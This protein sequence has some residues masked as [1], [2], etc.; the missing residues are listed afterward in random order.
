MTQTTIAALPTFSA[1]AGAPDT[2]LS[3]PLAP[4]DLILVFGCENAAT[5][6]R[7]AMKAAGL[8]HAG[9]APKILLSGGV[10]N[11]TG[12]LEARHMNTTLRM[13]GVP[14]RDIHLETWSSNTLENAH[15]S[16]GLSPVIGLPAR[17]AVILINQAHASLRAAMTMA[18][19][20]PDALC[21]YAPV[22]SAGVDPRNWRKDAHMQALMMREALKI[23][24]YRARGD[25]AD[26]NR[27][28]LM[29]RIREKQRAARADMRAQPLAV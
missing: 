16:Q 26:I 1:A 18:A 20:W 25:I 13:L 23:P 19:Q 24:L 3:T 4:A 5:C 27:H 7:M 2:V 10:P 29:T 21:M 12:M 14:D 15:F 28:A 9:L 17:P 11:Q 6:T 8:Y 22:T